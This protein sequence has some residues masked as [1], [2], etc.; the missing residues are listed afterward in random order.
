MTY[1][2]KLNGNQLTICA[3]TDGKTPVEFTAKK[4]TKQEVCVLKRLPHAPAPP[5]E[6]DVEKLSKDKV[7][8]PRG[9]APVQALVKLSDDKQF[10]SVQT[11]SSWYEPVTKDVE[12]KKITIY[13]LKGKAT[14]AMFNLDAVQAYEVQRNEIIKIALT[15]LPK[16]L[17][18]ET[19]A[20]VI[21][22]GA[23]PIDPL[24]LR[25]LKDGTLLLALQP[26]L[27][28]APE[29]LPPPVK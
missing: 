14:T 13:V 6:I 18:E 25:L 29:A 12:G 3:G 10:I 28:R 27:V 2:Y 1:L 7:N 22:G 16:L 26:A 8:L 19:V 23:G 11:L 17:K 20:L 21:V 15:E 4:G 24:H 9:A 5:L